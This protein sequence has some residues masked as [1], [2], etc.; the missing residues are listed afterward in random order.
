MDNK[1][2]KTGLTV[3]R[4]AIA[5]IGLILCA[6][7]IS[8]ADS[9]MT[10]AD[11]MVAQGGSLNGAL[12][13]TYI[14]VVLSAA[15]AVIFGLINVI[16]NPK[17]NLGAVLGVVA[18]IVLFAVAYAGFADDSVPLKFQS[19]VSG[20]ISKMAGAGL[21]TLYVVTL[22]TLVAVVYAEVSKLLK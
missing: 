18:M 5:V 20:T 4:I 14:L 22:L 8:N 7:I 12:W 2:M 15:S 9:E 1:G 21:I 19:T 11:A 17:K 13:I 16:R 6:L 3:A 10:T